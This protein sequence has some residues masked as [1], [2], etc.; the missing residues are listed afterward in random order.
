MYPAG[1]SDPYNN[2]VKFKFRNH[3]NSR[4]RPQTESTILFNEFKSSYTLPKNG[5]SSSSPQMLLPPANEVCEGY[6]FT[7]VCLSTGWVG[8][9][10]QEGACVAE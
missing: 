7:G 5:D 2:Q 8:C 6:V 10:W 4:P 3:W 9:A 1:F